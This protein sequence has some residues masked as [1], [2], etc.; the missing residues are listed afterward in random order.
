MP[1]C[2]DVVDS[3]SASLP[4]CIKMCTGG[5]N[6]WRGGGVGVGVGVE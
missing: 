2:G 1:A 5:F 3:Y 4:K 6:A